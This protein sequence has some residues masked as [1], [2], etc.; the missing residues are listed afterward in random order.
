MVLTVEL[1]DLFKA[2]RVNYCNV[3]GNRDQQKAVCFSIA[4]CHLVVFLQTVVVAELNR[5][6]MKKLYTCFWA[7]LKAVK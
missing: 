7:E 2:K 3:D 6:Y 1:I 5:K 4:W